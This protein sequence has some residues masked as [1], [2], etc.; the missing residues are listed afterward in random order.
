M[1]GAGTANRQSW[2]PAWWAVL[3]IGLL[4]WGAA[5][6]VFYLTRDVIT[7]PTIVLIGSFLVPVTAVVW[8][9][10]HNPSPQLSPRRIIVAFTVAGTI[11]LLAAALAE[12]YL[13]GTGSVVN[14]QVGFIEELIKAVLI[15]IV[16]WGVRS[17][18]TRDGMVLGLSLIHI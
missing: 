9:L 12:H 6:G 5:I 11:G 14:L 8:Y 7:M 1:A 3:L 15:V 16:A 18:R 17:F 13:L 2:V 4:L 10:D